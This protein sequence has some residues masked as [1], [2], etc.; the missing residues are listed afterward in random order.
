MSL[1]MLFGIGSL[2]V[3]GLLV[4]LFIGAVLL[5]AGAS[6]EDDAVDDE[7]IDASFETHGVHFC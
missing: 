5:G 1:L 4:A 3:L 2:V 6:T 7:S